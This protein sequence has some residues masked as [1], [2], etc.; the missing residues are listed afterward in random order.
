[1][2]REVMRIRD[3]LI[4][5]Y[6]T[7]VYRGFWF[8]PER[9]ML[10]TMVDATQTHVTG[11]ARVKLFKGSV[12]VVGRKSPKSLY[13]ENVVTFERDEVYDQ[14]DATGFIRLNALRL[15]LRAMRGS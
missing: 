8:S 7:L 13:N 3:G 11:T 14:S 9:E 10:Q 4:P 1:M 5:E 6:A 2:D 15:R 12:Q